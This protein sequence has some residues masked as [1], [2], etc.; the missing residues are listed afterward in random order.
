MADFALGLT[1]TALE[2]TLSRVQSAIEEEGKLKVTV[3]NDLVFIT[4]EFQM[5]Q[6][7]LEVASKE[8]ANN[9][10]VKT[11]VRQLHDLALDVEDCLKLVVQLDN[12]SSWSWMWRV[13]PSFMAPPRHLYD[14]VDEM[15][16]LKARVED[17]SHRN[18][19]YNLISDSGSKH[20][21]SP[22]PPAAAA[23]DILREIWE[24]EGK[25]CTMDGLQ[26]LIT[27]GGDGRQ[28]ISVWE[29]LGGD[30]GAASILRKLYSDETV[31]HKFR[32]CAWVKL[33]HPFNPDG[34]LH[35]MLTQFCLSSQDPTNPGDDFPRRVRASLA[36]EDDL[37]K[38][39]ELKQLLSDQTYLV[40]LEEVSTI[41][42]WDFISSF[43][44]NNKNHS[45]IV[46]STKQLKIATSSTGEPNHVLKLSSG[47]PL[48]VF[49]NKASL[50]MHHFFLVSIYMSYS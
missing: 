16:Q 4:G 50:E 31:C 47:Q 45:R 32:R 22:A 41:V 42:E 24:A 20:V 17:V 5:M 12:S 44:P 15:K 14:A 7:F 27:T 30:I 3:Q 25:R 10:V 21:S 36:A 19:R 35:S 48:F 18:A 34:F 37:M 13:L 46:L 2:G 23:V 33:V 38:A 39:Q 29:S 6:S 49:L 9:K 8:R 26:R 28:V 1:K 40:I 43:L 11:W